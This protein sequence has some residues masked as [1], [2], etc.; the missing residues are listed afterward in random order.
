MPNPASW[1]RTLSSDFLTLP[2]TPATTTVARVPGG[3]FLEFMRHGLGAWCTA[4]VAVTDSDDDPARVVQ[5]NQE[6]LREH[7]AK[8][9]GT[10]TADTALVM[11]GQGPLELPQQDISVAS[12]ATGAG[13]AMSPERLGEFMSYLELVHAVLEGTSSATDPAALAPPPQFLVPPGVDFA[14]SDVIDLFS[15]SADAGDAEAV[16]PG[17]A[18]MAFQR[19][20]RAALRRLLREPDDRDETDGDDGGGA[21]AAQLAPAAPVSPTP[22]SSSSSG[23]SRSYLLEEYYRA[24]DDG[25]GIRWRQQSHSGAAAVGGEKDGSDGGRLAAVLADLRLDEEEDEDEEEE[26]AG[27][28][29]GGVG[30][31]GAVQEVAPEL[32]LPPPPPPPAPS[33]PA[34]LTE[35]AELKLQSRG[36]EREGS[37]DF[38]LDAALEAAGTASAR[39]LAA[40]SAP[41]L[42]TPASAVDAAVGPVTSWAVLKALPDSGMQP[43][44]A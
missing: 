38:D 31:A 22:A 14:A 19:H 6:K 3:S 39:A 35:E 8:H 40:R 37:D 34:F 43:P 4:E 13:P 21:V 23:L 18:S 12:D 27:E 1:P 7:S 20:Q 25:S 2:S 29:G 24:D 5:N 11:R 15:G 42:A 28:N 26:E 36:G 33:K 17:G 44:L 9:F 41:R 30:D 16:A 32:P 10:A